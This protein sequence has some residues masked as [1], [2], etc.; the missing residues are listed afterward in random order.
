MRKLEIIRRAPSG[1]DALIRPPD[2][3][4]CKIGAAVVVLSE[5]L[6]IM[7]SDDVAMVQAFDRIVEQLMTRKQRA[8]EILW[9]TLVDV[10]Y[11][12]GDGKGRIEERRRREW[13]E[14]RV[15]AMEAAVARGENAGSS[16]GMN[17]STIAA[18]VPSRVWSSPA[19]PQVSSMRIAGRCQCRG[20]Q[21][22]SLFRGAAAGV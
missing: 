4:P 8:E 7:F 14:R 6:S 5:A 11:R 19:T 3:G 17:M 22:V 18:S 12:H 1:F 21:K 20:M 2:G 10:L 9:A 16:A 13:M 15:R